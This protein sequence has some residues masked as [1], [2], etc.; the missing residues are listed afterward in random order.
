[1]VS[2]EQGTIIRGKRLTYI[3][4]EELGANRFTVLTPQYG[5]TVMRLEK[6]TETDRLQRL[7]N[8]LS[9]LMT[10][11]NAPPE[12]RTHLLRLYDFCVTADFKFLVAS[13]VGPSIED[14]QYKF[15]AM[16]G[17]RTVRHI[18][19]ET[20]KAIREVHELGYVLRDVRP[21]IFN[22]GP[23]PFGEKCIYIGTYNRVAYKGANNKPKRTRPHVRVALYASRARLRERECTIR[24]DYES[25]LYMVM[26]LYDQRWIR[27][28]QG[29]G[30]EERVVEI[31][32]QKDAI[33]R[34]ESPASP[35]C[36]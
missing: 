23:S 11:E 21:S 19:A 34:C 36:P 13:R 5:R 25:W 22:I 16:F 30:R 28:E 31:L 10:A 14:L 17:P 6:I 7:N 8:E 15:G 33:M 20:L 24:D 26:D 35:L 9:L 18:A 32:K 4:D 12:H 3:V 27:D 29:L 1:Q 2:L